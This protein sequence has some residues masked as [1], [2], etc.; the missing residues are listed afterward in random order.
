M[1]GSI[2][3]T[4]KRQLRELS[5]M[6]TAKQHIASIVLGIGQDEVMGQLSVMAVPGM[7]R[8]TVRIILARALQSLD[9]D[10]EVISRGKDDINR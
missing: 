2:S 9:T 4:N 10:L 3:K 8:E 6:L 5:K 7:D 1:S